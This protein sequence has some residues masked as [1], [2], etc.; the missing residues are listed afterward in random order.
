[1]SLNQLVTRITATVWALGGYFC[2][3]LLPT[4]YPRPKAVK[5]KLRIAII[6]E[7]LTI[8]IPSFLKIVLVISARYL[9]TQRITHPPG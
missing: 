5:A 4:A 9:C 3:L 2:V 1:M 6:S 7:I 8:R